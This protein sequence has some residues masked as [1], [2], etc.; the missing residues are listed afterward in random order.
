VDVGEI[1]Q[2]RL[3][4]GGRKFEFSVFL[5]RMP[6]LGLKSME[7]RGKRGVRGCSL[8]KNLFYESMERYFSGTAL[9][10]FLLSIH[11]RLKRRDWYRDAVSHNTVTTV[12][13]GPNL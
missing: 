13:P 1:A 9:N 4:T 3:H 10:K 12:C 6:N 11:A 7:G 8:I 5:V 2:E